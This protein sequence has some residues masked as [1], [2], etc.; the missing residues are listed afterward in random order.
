MDSFV[1]ER[2]YKILENDKYT[3][4]VLGRIIGG[5]CEL[6]FTDHERLIIFFTCNP[7]PVWIWT[8]N[9]VT[10]EEKEKVYLYICL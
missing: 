2:D 9:D 8:P 7:Y 3:F 10:N 6:L 5:E 1:D 4:F